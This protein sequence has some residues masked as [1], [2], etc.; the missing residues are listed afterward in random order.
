MPP[1][2]CRICGKKFH[3]WRG[4]TRHLTGFHKQPYDRDDDS[5]IYVCPICGK[6]FWSERNRNTHVQ[7]HPAD[8]L[9]TWQI[10]DE[11]SPSPPADFRPEFYYFAD[12]QWQAENDLNLGMDSLEYILRFKNIDD[13]KIKKLDK[14]LYRCFRDLIKK[15]VD[16]TN[17]NTEVDYTSVVLLDQHLPNGQL[18]VPFCRLDEVGAD[19]IATIVSQAIQ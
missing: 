18:S 16:L 8:S 5:P 10:R 11:T 7:Q 9:G 6:K 17:A 12:L 3:S 15:V 2:E 14:I 13:L 4:L 1:F 19:Q